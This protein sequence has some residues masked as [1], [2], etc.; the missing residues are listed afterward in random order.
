MR[1]LHCFRS[2]VGG[3]FRHVRDLIDEHVAAGHDVG[4]ICDITTGGDY[5]DQLF[6]EL[7]PKLAL[8]LNRIAINRSVTPGDIK[9]LF[10]SY[11]HI[12]TLQPD[13]IHGHGAKGGAIARVIGTMLR[14]SKQRVARL[15]SPHGGSLHFDK[16][17]LKGRVFFRAERMMERFTDAL[18]FVCDYEKNTYITKIGQP[19][20]LYR[21]IYNGVR[22]EEFEPIEIAPNAADFLYIGMMRDLKGPQIFID[23]IASLSKQ[24]G[25]TVTAHMVGDGPDKANYIQKIKSLGLEDVITMHEAMPARSAFA[26]AKTVLVPSLAEAMPYIVLEA[27]AAGKP[28]IASRVGGIAEILGA[29]HPDLIEAGKSEPLARAMEKHLKLTPSEAEAKSHIEEF[30]Q[31]FSASA[32]GAT[33]LTLYKDLL[34]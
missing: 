14:V 31:R 24:P 15:Y 11:Q 13:I 3:V 22:D 27:A 6:R 19:L 16:A 23:A 34:N 29:N 21:T 33:M 17:S 32:M 28:I 4:I 20:P 2:P 26:L 25:T 12:K 1:I 10:Q 8:G 9:T 18:C 5:E 30:K 7:E